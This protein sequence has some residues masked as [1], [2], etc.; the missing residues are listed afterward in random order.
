MKPILS[1]FLALSCISFGCATHNPGD[2]YRRD[3]QTKLGHVVVEDGI[4][5]SEANIIAENYFIR[6]TPTLCGAVEPVSDGGAHWIANTDLGF[7]PTPT[8]EPIRI[9]KQTGRIA[10]S[11]GPTIENP[12]ALWFFSG[13]QRPQLLF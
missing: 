3:L 2:D 7:I 11:D 12:K 4:N 6:F 5:D 10:W 13:G 8:R 9:N 1:T